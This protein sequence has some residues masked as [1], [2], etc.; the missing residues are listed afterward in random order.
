MDI[1]LALWLFDEKLSVVS[2]CEIKLSM[3]SKNLQTLEL[4]IDS[5]Q[6]Q[7][8]KY[9]NILWGVELW[10]YI[11]QESCIYRWRTLHWD[12]KDSILYY[13]YYPVYI[14]RLKLARQGSNFS[15][16]SLRIFNI[17]MESRSSF[18]SGWT[19][20]WNML[21]FSIVFWRLFTHV[22]L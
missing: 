15:S 5:G 9:R 10:I 13:D 16:N 14:N 12:I 6:E 3:E 7:D 18:Y 17:Y 1:L 21:F 2:L 22:W 11:I 8:R 20:W 4:H 19:W